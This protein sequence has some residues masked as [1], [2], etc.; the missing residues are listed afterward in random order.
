MRAIEVRQYGG[1]EALAVVDRA[2]LQPGPGELLVDV[3]AAG[4]NFIDT[5]QR[6]GVYQVPLPFHPGGEGAGVVRAVGEGVDNI[7]VGDHVGWASGSGC[8]AEQAVVAAD[9]TVP[10]PAGVADEV[11]AAVLLQGITAH[12]LTASVHRIEPGDTA[13]VHAGAGGVGLLLT[14]IVKIL[15]GR[16]IA[17]VS[18]AEKAELSRGAGADEVVGYDDFAAVARRFTDGRGVDVVYDGVGATTFDQSLD[19]LR[20]R[21]MMALYGAASGPV[22]PFD[23]QLLNQKGS[24]FLTRPTMAHY[25]ATR[26]ELVSRTDELFGWI[27]AGKLDVRIGGRYP[28]EQAGQAHTD[29]QGRRTTGKQLLIP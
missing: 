18:T 17:T 23:P 19:S 6:S 16:V 13:V 10:V 20:P 27:A 8:Y 28:L 1:P 5:Y 24:L 22:P 11:A 25:I 26:E 4:V 9:K 2:D 7:A 15:G 21:G 14:Q 3:A 12:Y 29:L